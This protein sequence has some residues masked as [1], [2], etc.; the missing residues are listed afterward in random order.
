MKDNSVKILGC[1]GSIPVSGKEYEKYGGATTCFAIK[2]DGQLLVIDAGTGILKLAE[3]L[4]GEKEIPI[5]FTHAHTDHILGFP[6]CT[7]VFDKAMSFKLYSE[8]M[9]I[10][11][12]IMTQPIW[13]VTK[14]LLPA[15]IEDKQLQNSFSIGSLKIETLDGIHTGKVKI[16][17]IIGKEKA[18]VVMTDCTIAEHKKAEFAEFAKGCDLLLIDGQYS[19]ADWIG[20]EKF[21]HNN[22]VQ[23]SAFA[24]ECGAKNTRIVHH[25]PEYKD[26]QL[27]A[28]QEK[29]SEMG[30]ESRFAYEG[31]EIIL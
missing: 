7:K 14:D 26:E 6:M 4:N 24:R 21:G 30:Y 25:A 5:L 10:I 13:P 29:L 15:Q 16:L 28:A 18:V 31:E 3:C 27:D 2:M 8:Y 23:A 19:E 20:R 1:R 9:D 12:Y 11:G 17:K 22:Y